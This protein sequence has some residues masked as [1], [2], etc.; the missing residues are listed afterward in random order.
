LAEYGFDLYTQSWH[1]QSETPYSVIPNGRLMP[2]KNI[3]VTQEFFEPFNLIRESVQFWDARDG[4][5]LGHI[6]PH[7]RIRE[8]A[9]DD[10]GY[11]I[12]VTGEDGSV[13]IWG[14]PKEE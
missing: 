11:F 9:F 6:Q 8:F 14:V 1:F 7:Y 5:I 4:R 3:L 2:N 12:A 10:Q 13:R